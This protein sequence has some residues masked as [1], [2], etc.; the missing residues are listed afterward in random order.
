MTEELARTAEREAELRLAEVEIRAEKILDASHR[1]AARLA[2]DIRE[3]RGLRSRLAEALRS[4]AETHIAL[5]ETLESDPAQDDP[6]VQGLEEGT[7][8]FLKKAD[9][10]HPADAAGPSEAEAVPTE[11]ADDATTA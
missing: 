3:M 1:R 10:V 9:R 8:A 6:L 4:A 5:L 7:V 2:Q 11:A